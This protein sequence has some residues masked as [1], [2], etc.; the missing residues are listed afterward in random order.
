MGNNATAPQRQAI[1]V[2]DWGSLEP[3]EFLEKIE[4]LKR[5][6][7]LRSDCLVNVRESIER[8]IFLFST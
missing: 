1:Q 2:Q 3:R 4:L 5:K 7:L 8:L 6:A